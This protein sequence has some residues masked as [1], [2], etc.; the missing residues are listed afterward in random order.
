M[1]SGVFKCQERAWNRPGKGKNVGEKQMRMKQTNKRMGTKKGK[2]RCCTRSQ[3][4]AEQRELEAP[5]K[6]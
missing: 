1:S 3:S 6:L 5:C 4:H 2:G